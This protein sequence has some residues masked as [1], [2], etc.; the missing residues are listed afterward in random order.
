MEASTGSKSLVFLR[1]VLLLLFASIVFPTNIKSVVIALFVIASVV[2]FFKSKNTFNT[3]FF[4]SNALIYVVILVTL[5]YS[6]NVSYGL[7]KLTTLSSL[8]VFPFCFSLFSKEDIAYFYS[9]LQKYLVTYL[10]TVVMFNVLPFLWFYGTHYS[11]EEML[12]HFPT[13]MRVD[14]GKFGI[15]PI[16]LSMHCSVAIVFSMYVLRQTSVKWKIITILL[17]DAILVLFLLLYAKKGPILA[18]MLVSFLFILFQRKKTIV[19]PYVLAIV[20]LVLLMIAIPRTRNKF[21]ELQKIEVIGKGKPTSTNIRYTIYGLAKELIF[22]NPIIGYGVGDYKQVLNDKYEISGNK[23]LKD[24]K[25]NAH[26]QFLSLLLIGGVLAL[27]AF[28]FTLAVNLV[29]AIRFNNELLILIILFYSVV[30]LTENVLEREAGVVYFALFLNFL[31]AK[32]LFTHPEN[33]A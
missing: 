23:V 7:K 4:I 29:F 8:V 17:L 20:G 31:S 2:H 9:H 19:K 21:L 24:G 3:R 25:Y 16:Y 22:E 18:L 1:G 26:N 27:L 11:F 6:D 13:V 5:L 32:T 14:V 30:M 28:L 15:H 33:V 10:I 12:I